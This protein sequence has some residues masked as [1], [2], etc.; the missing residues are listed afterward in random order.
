MGFKKSSALIVSMF[1]CQLLSAVALAEPV[2]IRVSSK[3]ACSMNCIQVASMS[4]QWSSAVCSRSEPLPLGASCR[5]STA[6][7]ATVDIEFDDSACSLL[8][9][10]MFTIGQGSD[11]PI[12]LNQPTSSQITFHTNR[13]PQDFPDGLNNMFFLEGVDGELNNMSLWINDNFLHDDDIFD[14][15]VQLSSPSAFAVQGI[16]ECN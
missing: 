6:T 11:L 5:T 9:M 7:S 14:A 16:S 3:T 8:R 1:A 2:S 4:G 12:N 15:R 13:I 10:R